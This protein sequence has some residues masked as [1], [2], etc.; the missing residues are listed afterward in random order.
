MGASPIL[1]IAGKVFLNLVFVV[2]RGSTCSGGSKPI[3][4]DGTELPVRLY[5]R[6]CR[7]NMTLV[8]LVKCYIPCFIFATYIYNTDDVYIV[9]SRLP[10]SI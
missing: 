6:I 1:I 3:N 7:T 5:S 8:K 10:F 9:L 4:P 2:N